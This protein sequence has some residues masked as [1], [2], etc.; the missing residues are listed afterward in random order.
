MKVLI[1]S[2]F[3]GAGKTTFIKELANQTKR[4]YVIL[5]NEFGDTNIDSEILKNNKNISNVWELTSGCACCSTKADFMSSLIVIDNSLNP[6]FLIVEPS[7]IAMLSNMINNITKLNYDRIQI[8]PPITIIDAQTYF[9]YKKKYEEIFIN[10]IKTASHIQLSKVE[11]LSSEELDLIYKD[12]YSINKNSNIYI[13]NYYDND[14]NYWN[15][16]FSG[17]LLN[18]EDD[19]I[20]EVKEKM[21]NVTYKNARVRD[22]CDV[23]FFLNKILFNYYGDI[24]RAKGTFDT[25]D[26][27]IHFDLVDK[28]Y[29]IYF[30]NK[31]LKHEIN[32]NV[33]LIG[34]KIDKELA[35]A[36]LENMC[37]IM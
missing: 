30:S 12:I 9:K 32:N 31:K 2:G 29:S 22:F 36:E 6:E 4:E 11:N 3:L 33:V 15:G 16:L 1:V 20:K 8:L 24:N 25:V 7:G 28:D 10:Q 26:Y 23:I 5:E 17:K 37:K 13:E 35:F 14:I 19:K 21:I 27:S 34:K 18:L